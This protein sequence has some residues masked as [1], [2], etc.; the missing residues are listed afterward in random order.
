[1]TLQTKHGIAVSAETVRRW[2][3]EIGWGWKRAQLIA[4]DDD[5]HRTDRLALIRLHHETLQ[6]HEVMVF[7]DALDIHLL[8]KIGAAWRLQGPQEEIMTAVRT[9]STIWLGRSICQ[10]ARCCIVSVPGKTMA[11]FVTF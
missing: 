1:M 10:P 9:R 11:Y 4:K 3:H 7:A 6:A 8:P 2:L 5:P